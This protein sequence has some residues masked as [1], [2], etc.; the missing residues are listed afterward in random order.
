M[1]RNVSGTYTLPT[2]NPVA[3]GTTI[4]ATWGNT[5]MDDVATEITASLDRNGQGGML[6]GF[7]AFSGTVSLPGLSF[8]D[9][10]SSGW[11]RAA[12]ADIRFSVLGTDALQFIDDSATASGSQQPLLIWDGAAFKGAVYSGGPLG[13]PLSGVMTNVTGT[14]SGLTAGNVTT[15]ANL[16]GHVTSVGNAAILGSFTLAQLNTAISDATAAILGAN[17]FTGTQNFADNTLQR[18]NLLDYGEVTNA[19]GS[20]GGGTQDIDLTLGN[21]V[22]ATVDTSANTFTFSNPTASDEKCGF[23]LLLT[24]GGSQ[25]VNWPGSVDW[26]AAT[27]PTLTAA[28]VDKLV[29]ET[30][31]GGT[32]WEGNLAGLAYA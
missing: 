8:T 14:A 26:P 18:A 10:V 19:I 4:T 30:T 1:P 9:E 13:T 11:Y 6:A 5:T 16:T 15:N 27:A 24:N 31:D 3:G 21:S 32:T 22:T 2:G 29:F 20:T 17:T 25:T 23:T 7:K 28:G 12:A